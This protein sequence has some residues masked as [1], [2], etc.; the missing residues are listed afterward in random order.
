MEMKSTLVSYYKCLGLKTAM[1]EMLVD[2]I[3]H[4]KQIKAAS[5]IVL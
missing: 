2:K 5:V 3:H 4:Y 1:K